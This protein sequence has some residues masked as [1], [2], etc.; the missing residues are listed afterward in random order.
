MHNGCFT[1][2]RMFVVELLTPVTP[3][4][5]VDSSLPS[6][7]NSINSPL[8]SSFYLALL[9]ENM[10]S[11]TKPEVH[12]VSHYRQRK[13]EPRP[14]V[15]CTENSVKFERWFFDFS[16][17]SLSALQSTCFI[18]PFTLPTLFLPE[19]CIHGLVVGSDLS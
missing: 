10:T 9:C 19:D 6:S 2:M 7:K 11:S 16:T 5:S 1:K 4:F 8:S 18:N 3:Y 12:N 14:Q 17:L 13:T 15:T